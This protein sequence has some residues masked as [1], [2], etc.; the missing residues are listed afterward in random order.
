VKGF[1]DNNIKNI[2]NENMYKN[3][4]SFN[5]IIFGNTG[6]GKSTLLNAVLKKN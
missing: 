1:F 5:I 3:I 2:N 6:V 4:N